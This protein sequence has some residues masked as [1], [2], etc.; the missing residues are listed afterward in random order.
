MSRARYALIV[1]VGL[2]IAAGCLAL[3]SAAPARNPAPAPCPAYGA[4][5][6]VR[7]PGMAQ[8]LRRTPAVVSP[9]PPAAGAYGAAIGTALTFGLAGRSTTAM[10]QDKAGAPRAI[11]LELAARL[12]LTIAAR[13][14]REILLRAALAA[15]D[16]RPSA[17]GS[18]EPQAATRLARE[19]ELPFAIRMRDDGNTVGYRFDPLA[20]PE[21]RNFVRALVA[22]LRWVVPADAGRGWQAEE[23]DACGAYLASY[24]RT[25]NAVSKQKLRYLAEQDAPR[26][27]GGGEARFDAT[28]GWLESGAFEESL[29]LAVPELGLRV[30]QDSRLHFE[31]REHS[32]NPAPVHAASVGAW[33][34]ADTLD[35]QADAIATAELRR[36]DR[37]ASRLE[38]VTAESL[39]ARLRALE[40]ASQLDTQE[41]C[42]VREELEWL[43]RL[44]P[45]VL[46]TLAELVEDSDL[47]QAARLTILITIGNAQIEPAQDLLSRWLL[48]P[49]VGD[50]LRQA[51]A[52][53]S[54]ALRQPSPA[55]TAALEH[56]I[57]HDGNTQ[58]VRR[59]ALLALGTL[60]NAAP[61][62]VA[63]LLAFE[64][65]ARASGA[66]GTWLEALGN[67]GQPGILAA[68]ER[69]LHDADDTIR[70]AAVAALRKLDAHGATL[71]LA[72][73]LAD[74]SA[75]TV[76]ARAAEQLAT[77]STEPALAALE[78]AL[79]HDPD[80]SVRQA[81]LVALD[82][83]SARSD[84]VLRLLRRVAAQDATEDLRAFAA[85]IAK[86]SAISR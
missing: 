17:G 51:A 50:G 62:N 3:F 24:S 78:R 53:A 85:R 71:A 11:T 27:D 75:P 79:L 21:A 57:E 34:S 64:T 45:E 2:A 38:G 56:V 48:D 22:A 44:R 7:A 76:R 46:Q 63:R 30:R 8:H 66:L 67:A 37:F 80:A 19:L 54:S 74:D 12:E 60:S 72:T 68:A 23:S 42:A 5:T 1:M 6:P 83:A 28:I 59:T 32:W 9:P 4:P 15:V 10:Q 14:G 35:G 77:R 81:A 43:I 73:V 29:E 65:R 31:L 41:A 13:E 55:V 16:L 49:T 36:L 20:G 70:A 26:V 40:A 52:F 47:P 61:D 69:Y 82:R 25:A 33:D 84:R 58:R 86:R 39:V 18:H